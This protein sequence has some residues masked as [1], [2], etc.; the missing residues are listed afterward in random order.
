MSI[1]SLGSSLGLGVLLVASAS[2]CSFD[3]GGAGDGTEGDA[4]GNAES[5]ESA[6]SGGESQ[7]GESDTSVS[8]SSM[9][10]SAGDGD[11]GGAS[12]SASASASGDGDSDPT[13]GDGDGDGESS[14][15]G[16]GEGQSG[17]VLLY[18]IESDDDA[19]ENQQG[20][21]A[22]V[23]PDLEM[24]DDWEYWGSGQTIGIRF[25]GVDIPVGATIT[26]AYL[27]FTVDRVTNEA[28]SLQV[29]GQAG[30]NPPTFSLNNS[31]LSER[32]GTANVLDWYDIA[33][34][35]AVGDMQQSPD[36]SV[37]VQELVD[38]GAW[39]PGQPMAFLI[40]GTGQRVATSYDAGPELAPRLYVDWVL[41]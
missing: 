40:R 5:G 35:L 11:S 3:S 6:S 23:S 39:A 2:A 41:P 22:T 4:S 25:Q 38:Q 17:S 37:V 20:D 15:D 12:T 19:E 24:A 32:P 18:V 21:M 28:T 10:A 14:G 30:T 27:E 31:D 8:E 7:S 26:N 9:D 13:A 16:D 29:Y 1:G 33:P 34:W 36:L